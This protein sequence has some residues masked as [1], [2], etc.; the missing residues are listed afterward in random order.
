MLARRAVDI[1]DQGLADLVVF[2]QARLDLAQLDTETT[3]LHLVVDPSHVLDQ[4]FVAVTGDVA[5]AVQPAAAL[6]VER[7]G[8]KTLGGQ[9]RTVVVT[10]RQQRAADQQLAT[11]A[12]DRRIEGAVEDV[13]AP[14]A[15]RSAD[16]HQHR[17]GE[18]AAHIG[19]TLQVAGGDGGFGRAIGVEQADVFQ[20]RLFPE[21]DA[22]GR[23]GLARGADLA[24]RTEVADAQA[25]EI[26]DQQVPVGRTQVGHGDART[27]HL[28]MEGGA[29][30]DLVASYHHPRAVAQRRE[31]LLDET[32]EVQGGEQQDAIAGLQAEVFDGHLAM[33]TQGPMVD[34]HALGFA[35]GTR[36]VDHIGQVVA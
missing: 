11:A 36:G 23:H 35:G 22:F 16:G 1:D 13:H 14:P 2:L 9:R 6:L 30:P 12:L 10:P 7:V 29:V 25:V 21:R 32:V 18:I 26:L 27:Q 17:S 28:T 4:A 8:D 31:Q 34:S 19:R 24:Q 15:Q 5:G 33:G 20:S 3:D